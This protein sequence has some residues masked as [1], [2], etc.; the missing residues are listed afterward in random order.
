MIGYLLNGM[1]YR[2]IDFIELFLPYSAYNDNTLICTCNVMLR[3]YC[4]QTKYC[5]D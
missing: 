3:D 4:I 1:A 2:P 5:A